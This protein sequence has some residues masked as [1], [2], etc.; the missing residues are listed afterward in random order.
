MQR[1]CAE[2]AAHI[3]AGLGGYTNAVAVGLAHENRLHRYPVAKFQQAVAS[4]YENYNKEF[5][6][7]NIKKIINVK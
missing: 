2:Y 4:A 3:A 5:G 6:A 1:R 7:D